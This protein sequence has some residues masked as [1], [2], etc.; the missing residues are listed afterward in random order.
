LAQINTQLFGGDQG[1]LQ[2]N[3]AFSAMLP[4]LIA[5]LPT[6]INN[7]GKKVRKVDLVIEFSRGSGRFPLK[8]SQYV[9][10]PKLNEFNVFD[11]SPA[12]Q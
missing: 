6:M 8:V 2:G 11:D 5:E 4:M 3:A 9:I 10:D 12:L 1:A 7:I